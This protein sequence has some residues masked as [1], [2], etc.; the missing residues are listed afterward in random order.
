LSMRNIDV[1]S[2]HR[3][4]AVGVRV[5]KWVGYASYSTTYTQDTC[6]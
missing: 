6:E 2:C 3:A 4:E 5:G 1:A